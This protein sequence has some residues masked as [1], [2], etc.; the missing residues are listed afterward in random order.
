M[1][2]NRRYRY[3]ASSKRRSCFFKGFI[4]GYGF[5]IFYIFTFRNRDSF[6]GD[7]IVNFLSRLSNYGNS[8]KDWDI[9]T[10]FIKYL[11]YCSSLRGYNFKNCLIG[12][13]FTD[14]FFSF[15]FV[16]FFFIPFNNKTGFN[17][18][19]FFWHKHWSS[20]LIPPYIN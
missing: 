6:F 20:H 7:K 9:V 15:Y 2:C 8:V 14:R 4:W 11:K 12:F 5:L 13:H 16:P 17:R 19:S 18:L 3:W 10:F 1:P